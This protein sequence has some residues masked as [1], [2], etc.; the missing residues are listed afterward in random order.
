N[1]A[2]ALS[3]ALKTNSTLT[4]LNLSYNSIGSYGAQALSK[5]RNTESPVI[6]IAELPMGD[7]QRMFPT[8]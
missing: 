8:R 1:G 3:E 5:A 2:V 6:I 7:V 4:A